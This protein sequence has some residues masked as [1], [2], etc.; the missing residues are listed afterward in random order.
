MF[1]YVIVNKSRKKSPSLNTSAVFCK[2]FVVHSHVGWLSSG[3]H[4][5]LGLITWSRNLS[6]LKKLNYPPLTFGFKLS[7]VKVLC[8][9][10]LAIH[11]IL[12]P[13]QTSSLFSLQALHLISSFAAMI[14][15][16]ATWGRC[17][18]RH[19][20]MGRKKVFALWIYMVVFLMRTDRFVPAEDVNIKIYYVYDFQIRLDLC[21]VQCWEMFPFIQGNGVFGVSPDALTSKRLSQRV[22]KEGSGRD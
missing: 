18:T 6:T 12:L 11:P 2:T 10:H 1:S 4:C 9:F 3:K 19:I 8:L 21:H 22:R 15:T 16:T 20:N 17:L 5:G 14:I 7:W 13:V